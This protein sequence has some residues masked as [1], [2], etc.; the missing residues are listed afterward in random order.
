MT[1]LPDLAV[2]LQRTKPDYVVYVPKS[3]DGSTFDTGNEHFL[4]FDGP[5]GSMMAVWTQS[6]YEGIKD[7][8]R[9]TRLGDIQVKGKAEAITTYSAEEILMDLDQI[10]SDRQDQ[11]A[12]EQTS[13]EPGSLAGLR[14][15]VF[16]PE[17]SIPAQSSL[18]SNIFSS[19]KSLFQDMVTA[20]E[21]I[22][23]D[24]HE[25]YVFKKYLQSKWNELL[26]LSG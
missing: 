1:D 9:C 20:A 23:K 16:S 6:T 26:S 25:E 10:L 24:Y 4:V 14:E 21:D 3:T 5:D 19:L 18:D 15:S 8:I 17:F 7:Y 11:A 12:Q 22:A 2:E 13:S